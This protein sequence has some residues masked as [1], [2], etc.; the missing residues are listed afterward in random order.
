MCV[1][2]YSGFSAAA[3]RRDTASRDLRSCHR[4]DRCECR[5]ID[6][7]S[8]RGGVAACCGGSVLPAKVRV[9][10]RISKRSWWANVTCLEVM[11][12]FAS[13][14]LLEWFM[15]FVITT[16]RKHSVSVLVS[17]TRVGLFFG[18]LDWRNGERAGN[19]AKEPCGKGFSR[20]T[21]SFTCH[22][23][24]VDGPWQVAQKAG[25]FGGRWLFLPAWKMGTGDLLS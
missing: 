1:P 22:G 18:V 8:S 16:R 14:P 21:F 19:P 3:A 24:L 12:A 23:H 25:R 10:F 6:R 17:Q 20:E 9:C 2:A 15:D 7:S 11:Q 5:A 4:L 13:A